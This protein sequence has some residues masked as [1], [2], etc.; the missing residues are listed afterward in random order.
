MVVAVVVGGGGEGER[1][2]RDT[3]YLLT[4]SK[5]V[6]QGKANGSQAQGESQGGSEERDEQGRGW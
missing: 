6:Q 4:L 2:A 1:E 5:A 3:M